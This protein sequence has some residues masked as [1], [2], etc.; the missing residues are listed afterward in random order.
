MLLTTI[1]FDISEVSTKSFYGR[2]IRRSLHIREISAGS[3][4]SSSEEEEI[5]LDEDND[6]DYIG[7]HATINLGKLEQLHYY[8]DINYNYCKVWRIFL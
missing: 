2:N 6:P 3:D 8:T 1:I 4:K 5:V 7:D